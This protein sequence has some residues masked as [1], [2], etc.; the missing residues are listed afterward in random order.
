M[1]SKDHSILQFL[2]KKNLTKTPP[3]QNNKKTLKT[4]QETRWSD[5]VSEIRWLRSIG[6]LFPKH[7]DTY[8][9][10]NHWKESCQLLQISEQYLTFNNTDFTTTHSVLQMLVGQLKL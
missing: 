9:D 8:S 7:E 3:H 2:K 1:F 6:L 10:K 4:K 5:L